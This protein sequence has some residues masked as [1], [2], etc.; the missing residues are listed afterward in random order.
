[1]VKCSVYQCKDCKTVFTG[2]WYRWTND[3]GPW[4]PE[5][6]YY[7]EYTADKQKCPECGSNKLSFTGK[8]HISRKKR[9]SMTIT[10]DKCP[11]LNPR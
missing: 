5:P 7:E 10:L 1:M 9:E 6:Y 3:D 8:V 11:L 2:K 4:I